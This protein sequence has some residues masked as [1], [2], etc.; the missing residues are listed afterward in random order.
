MAVACGWCEEGAC[1]IEYHSRVQNTRCEAGER[2]ALV[3]QSAGA[4]EGAKGGPAGS[5][6]AL[7]ASMFSGRRDCVTTNHR[8]VIKYM[9][10][11]Y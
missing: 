11:R 5:P 1:S 8:L 3:V 6:V 4:T 9:Y 7:N 10:R 2:A